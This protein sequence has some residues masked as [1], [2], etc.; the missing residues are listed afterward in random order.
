M[1]TAA[2]AHAARYANDN[3]T[4][5]RWST[6]FLCK[7]V[8]SVTPIGI[9]R[10]IAGKEQA[11]QAGVTPCKLSGRVACLLGHMED[12][13]ASFEEGSPLAWLIGYMLDDTGWQ[14]GEGKKVC[15]HLRSV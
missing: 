8:R 14:S 15:N 4:P 3:L 1:F 13:A 5:P 12:D 9:R 6:H 7:V 10:Q 11:A 2:K